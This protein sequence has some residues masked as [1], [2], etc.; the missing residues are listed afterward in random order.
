MTAPFETYVLENRAQDSRY[1]FRVFSGDQK[2]QILH[3][4]FV[5]EPN[6]YVGWASKDSGCLS[7]TD[8]RALYRSLRQNYKLVISPQS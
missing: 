7:I 2:V 1:E 5:K 4:Y 3:R 6:G 8:A